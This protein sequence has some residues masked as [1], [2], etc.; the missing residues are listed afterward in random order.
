MKAMSFASLPLGDVW[1]SGEKYSRGVL[2]G[3][4]DYISIRYGCLRPARTT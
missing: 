2:S 3:V 1:A 4:G